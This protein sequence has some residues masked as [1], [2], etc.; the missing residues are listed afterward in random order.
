GCLAGECLAGAPLAPVIYSQPQSR[1]VK[2]NVTV[3][4]KVDA[5]GYPALNYRWRRNGS[6]YSS[7]NSSS[8]TV[9][10]SISNSANFDVIITNSF[11]A[12]TSSVAVL[13]VVAQAVS[14]NQEPS[15][16]VTCSGITTFL[17]A[18]AAGQAPAG[19]QWRL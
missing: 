12:V 9:F 8:L 7:S 5:D 18:Q 14:I 3:T 11:G 10:G 6:T 19:Y 13:T 1:T 2:P 16:V 4:F 15:D 17:S